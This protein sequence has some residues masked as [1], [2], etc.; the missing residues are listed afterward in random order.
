MILPLQVV[1][2]LLVV[3]QF[4]KREMWQI[5]SHENTIKTIKTRGQYRTGHMQFG[6]CSMSQLWRLKRASGKGLELYETG[7]KCRL[8]PFSEVGWLN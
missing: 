3:F 2:F 5:P 6:C 8:L 7:S 4:L 1:D